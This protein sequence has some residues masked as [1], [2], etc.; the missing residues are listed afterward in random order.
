MA[1]NVY[2]IGVVCLIGWELHF[3]KFRIDYRLSIACNTSRIWLYLLTG[4]VVQ[5]MARLAGA[6]S[7]VGKDVHEVG[8][9]TLAAVVAGAAGGVAQLLAPIVPLCKG[10]VILHP[11][12]LAPHHRAGPWHQLLHP[13]RLRRT[14]NWEPWNISGSALYMLVQVLIVVHQ[15]PYVI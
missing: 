3:L 14:W 4:G 2:C 7:V 15:Y 8:E 6:C 13:D 1:L 10:F 5:N 9:A 11:G 12:H